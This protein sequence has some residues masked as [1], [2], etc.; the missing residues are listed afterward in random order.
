MMMRAARM[1]GRER[2]TDVLE[3]KVALDQKSVRRCVLLSRSRCGR[4]LSRSWRR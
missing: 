3:L 4:R 2:G 1:Y